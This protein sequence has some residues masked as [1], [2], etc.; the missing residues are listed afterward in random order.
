MDSSY[1]MYESSTTVDNGTGAAFGVFTL[2]YIAIIVLM[3]VSMWRLFVKAG[4]PGWAAIVPVY[5]QIVMLQIAGRPVWWVLLTMF[6]PFFG[7]WVAIVAVIDFVKS[8]GKSTGYG[9][10]AIFLPLIA[11]PMLAFSKST[12]YVRPAAEG[13]EGFVP[14]PDVNASTPPAPVAAPTAPVVS[15]PE[16]PATPETPPTTPPQNQ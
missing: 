4:K 11:Y 13:F 7:W 16:V 9:V 10:F 14:A 6:V 3:I 1:T 15:T 5:N 12:Q 2:V 8:Y